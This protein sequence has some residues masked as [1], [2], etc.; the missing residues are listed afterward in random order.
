VYTL[1]V[2]DSSG[3]L[4]G[5][6]TTS[7]YCNW[8]S[9]TASASQTYTVT[10]VSVTGTGN[11]RS[12]WSINGGQVVWTVSG[13]IST[14]GG[15]QEFPFPILSTG[16]LTLATCGPAGSTYYLYL[17]NAQS[18]KVAS[19][20]AASN[21]QTLSYTPSKRDLYRLRETAVSGPGSWSG[22]VSTY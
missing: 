13:S 22:T 4:L 14:T 19:A 2:Y 3:T 20:T 10:T 8:V 17:Y 11:Y 1:Y 16:Q 9:I 6:G 5:S 12:S 15:V 21:C 7:S 18:A